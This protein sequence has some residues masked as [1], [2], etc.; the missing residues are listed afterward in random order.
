V[1]PPCFPIFSAFSEMISGLMVA[2][3][4]A[5][6]GSINIIAGELDR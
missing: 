5:I 3:A 6:L 4:I 1:R 2:D